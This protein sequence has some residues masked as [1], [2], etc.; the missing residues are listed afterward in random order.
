MQLLLTFMN[1]ICIAKRLTVLHVLTYF[2]SLYGKYVDLILLRCYAVS[3]ATEFFDV[4]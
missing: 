3:F 4:D 1:N 2:P